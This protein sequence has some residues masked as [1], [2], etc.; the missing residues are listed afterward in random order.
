[1]TDLR[2]E[3]ENHESQIRG[4]PE[5]Q[6]TIQVRARTLQ[7]LLCLDPAVARQRLEQRTVE[8]T[9][10]AIVDIFSMA[11]STEIG[12]MPTIV[13]RSSTPPTR[14]ASWARAPRLQGP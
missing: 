6:I 9:W 12:P 5:A 14:R 7:L 8:I 3:P 2:I 13:D 1:M 4:V 10:R 11:G